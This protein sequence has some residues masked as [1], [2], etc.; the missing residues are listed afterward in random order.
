MKCSEIITELEKTYPLCLA[1]GWDNPGLLAGRR[2]KEVKRIYISLDATYQ[3]IAAAKEAGVDMLLTHHPMLM[4]A[5][6]TVNNDD[7]IGRRLI[8][9]I[10]S[11]IS[12]YAMHTNYDVVTMAPLSR[13]MIKLTDDEILDVTYEDGDRTCGIGRVGSLPEGMTLRA[14]GEYV[15]RIFGLETVKIFGDLDQVVKRAAISP[16]SGKSLIAP[17]VK[18][19][20]EVLISGD[21]GH[22]DGID[23]VM[24]GLAVID[25]GHYGLEHIFVHQMERFIKDKFPSLQVDC[26]KITGPFQVI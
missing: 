17:A 21:I 6:K 19:K 23:A 16:G 14:C 10:Q 11:D 18:A 7:F 2:E 20:A 3:V 12:Y 26:E 5:V 13:D 8:E 9:L 25:A 4:S 24:Q 15:K 22:H 1:E